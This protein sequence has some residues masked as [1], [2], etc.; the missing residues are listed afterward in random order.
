MGMEVLGELMKGDALALGALFEQLVGLGVKKRGACATSM[1]GHV[2]AGA[3][4]LRIDA[5]APSA[6]AV[7]ESCPEASFYPKERSC[8]QS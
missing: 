5:L 4:L 6:Y 8:A 3:S 7:A 1:H 2:R